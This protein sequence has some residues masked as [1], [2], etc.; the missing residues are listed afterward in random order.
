MR[1]L[2]RKIGDQ[3]SGKTGIGCILGQVFKAVAQQRIEIAEE[4][5]G[6]AGVGDGA[7][8]HLDD[9]R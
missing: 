9:V 6:N 3:H 1:R 2:G 7:A 4:H 8:G 5:D